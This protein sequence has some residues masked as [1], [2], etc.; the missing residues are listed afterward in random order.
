MI[1]PKLRT[2]LD[3]MPSPVTDRPGL[4]IRD[5]FRYSDATLIIPPSLIPGLLLFDGTR[6]DLDLHADLA[7]SLGSPE[8]GSAAGQLIEALSQA[9]FLEDETYGK[10]KQGRISAFAESPVRPA[11]H[12]GSAYPSGNRACC[13][14]LCSSILRE[15]LQPS[16][17]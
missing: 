17:E 10:L 1:L 14:T 2:D 3:I 13:G 7:R 6:T 12:A 16:R 11:A 8:I 9:G 4:L 15:Q 5:R